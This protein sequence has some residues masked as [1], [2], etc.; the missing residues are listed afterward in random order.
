[1]HV[2]KTGPHPMFDVLVLLLK[3]PILCFDLFPKNPKHSIIHIY[4]Y[5]IIYV[6]IYIYIYSICHTTVYLSDSHFEIRG[7][8]QKTRPM[9]WELT[10][11]PTPQ[12]NHQHFCHRGICYRARWASC[13][14][15]SATL[16]TSEDSL[17]VKL[18]T[19]PPKKSTGLA[20]ACGPY[21]YMVN[22][23]K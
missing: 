6:Y 17:T 3:D 15:W 11:Q 2:Q 21:V 13:G 7:G 12:P 1:M 22:W 8:R 14:W 9:F 10:I 23:L 18:M 5:M 4:I 20:T 16:A 19:C